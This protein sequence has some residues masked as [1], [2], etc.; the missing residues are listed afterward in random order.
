MKNPLVQTDHFRLDQNRISDVVVLTSVA[1]TRRGPIEHEV[2]RLSSDQWHRI[3][4]RAVNVLTTQSEEQHEDE[5]V[6][7]DDRTYFGLM[8]GREIAVLLWALLEDRNEEA[9]EAIL[10][11]W[12]ELARE[13]RW[14]LYRKCSM[15]GQGQGRGWRRA[16][17]YALT[18][19]VD[20]SEPVPITGTHREADPPSEPGEPKPTDSKGQM[21]LFK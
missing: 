20:N 5:V 12:R 16:L 3:G 18:D 14:W 9:Q 11:S 8:P 13:E 4:E 1:I 2:C 15:P 10:L 6:D 21:E 7:S 17:L 19:R